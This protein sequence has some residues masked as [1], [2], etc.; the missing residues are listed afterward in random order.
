MIAESLVRSMRDDFGIRNNLITPVRAALSFEQVKALGLPA[1]QETA[2]D[3][4][5]NYDSFVRRYGHDVYELEAVAPAMLQTMLRDAIDGILDHDAF[6]AEAKQ[7]AM[8]AR[9]VSAARARVM[10]AMGSA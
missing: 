1:N 7:E 6:S 8:D 4:S 3:T 9:E 10:A 5:S 2:K